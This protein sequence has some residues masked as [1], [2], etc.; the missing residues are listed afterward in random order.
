MDNVSRHKRRMAI[1]RQYKSKS[2]VKDIATKD[3]ADQFLQSE[4][5]QEFLEASDVSKNLSKKIH[6]IDLSVSSEELSN[7]LSSMESQVTADNIL[8]PVFLGLLDGTMRAFNIGTKQ[9]FTATRLYEECA[10]FEYSQDY[11]KS[12]L[13][14]FT[15]NRNE[16][17]NK[18]EFAQ[19][20]QYSNGK[21]KRGQDDVISA[22]DGSKMKKTKDEHFGNNLKASDAYNADENIYKNSTHAKSKNQKEQ[23]AEADHVIPCEIICNELKANK[24]LSLSD[25]KEI[26]NSNE[27]LVI[28]SKKNNR[29]TKVGKFAKSREQLQK[30]IKQ[31]YAEDKS[32]KKSPLS[33]SDIKAR[34]KMVDKMENAKKSLDQEINKKVEENITSDRNT[35]K[36]LASDATASA[37]NQFTGDMLL[38]LM[39]PLYFELNDCFHSGIENGVSAATF[40]Q[41]LK[42]RL[43]RMKQHVMDNVFETLKGDV[44]SFFKNFVSMLLE[45][46]VN[47]FVGVFKQTIRV[48]KEGVKILFQIYPILKDSSKNSNQKGDAILK[49]IAGSATIFAGIGIEAWL[50]TVGLPEPWSIMLASILSAVLTTLTMYLLDKADFFGVN[51][52][53]KMK[54]VNELI[55]IDIKDGK[56]EL[57]G[58]FSNKLSPAL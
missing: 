20:T 29:G 18:N 52:D 15:E 5:D 37:M 47:C 14:S 45:G 23:S 19:N 40:K 2:H 10:S 35:Q 27:N 48:M 21:L 57:L 54:R 46:I 32:G 9:G 42:F 3:E 28:T 31:G 43:N 25:I 55:E 24:A 58:L 36:R 50:N 1:L 53:L 11:S 41:A 49:L 34:E 12:T 38:N 17:N 30:E 56:Q 33:Q 22:R 7:Y 6:Q 4:V 8:K 39:K 26:T 51:Q 13:D 44:F 16:I